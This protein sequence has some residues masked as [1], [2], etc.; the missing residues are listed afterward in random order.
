MVISIDITKPILVVISVIFVV[1]LLVVFRWRFLVLSPI[2]KWYD[3]AC[4][5]IIRHHPDWP[6]TTLEKLSFVIPP[7]AVSPLIGAW[8][9][10]WKYLLLIPAISIA[11]FA[12]SLEATYRSYRK[13][14]ESERLRQEL[15][16]TEQAREALHRQAQKNK[17]RHMKTIE[18][19]LKKVCCF[20]EN[21][22]ASIY[23]QFE[24]PKTEEFY[25]LLIARYSR[26]SN[27][28]RTFWTQFS[29]KFGV[30]GKGHDSPEGD[31]WVMPPCDDSD[32]AAQFRFIWDHYR[33]PADLAKQI[34]MLCKTICVRRIEKNDSMLGLFVV[35]SQ[36][37][38]PT[39]IAEIANRLVK[40]DRLARLVHAYHRDHIQLQPPQTTSEVRKWEEA[41]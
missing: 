34:S 23:I 9:S 40:D 19:R 30:C 27:Y 17:I 12:S 24:D 35:E 16:E 37:R 21:Q 39:L 5:K 15:R 33:V 26:H 6:Y 14:E 31:D 20:T 38:E 25:Y 1:M 28:Q 22:R 7:L 2:P 29:S 11:W 3:S 4:S 10:K 41:D 8:S 32:H 18:R 13:E 36:D